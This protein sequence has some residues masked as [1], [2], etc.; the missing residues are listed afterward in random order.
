MDFRDPNIIGS[1]Y[2]HDENYMR[3]VFESCAV[4]ASIVQF[5]TGIGLLA[6]H[7]GWSCECDLCRQRTLNTRA[8]FE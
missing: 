5:L 8:C 1:S 2:Y 6:E 4:A 7:Y 3:R